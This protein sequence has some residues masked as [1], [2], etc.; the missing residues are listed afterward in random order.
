MN[1]NNSNLS[2]LQEVRQNGGGTVT[3]HYEDGSKKR[4]PISPE[5]FKNRTTGDALKVLNEIMSD[6]GAI[7]FEIN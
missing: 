4:Q 6:Y 7:S 3:Y 1:T 5:L 2:K